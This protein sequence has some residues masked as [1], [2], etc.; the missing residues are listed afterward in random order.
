M[1]LCLLAPVPMS[2]SPHKFSWR[3]LYHHCPHLPNSHP[4]LRPWQSTALHC[5]TES[6]LVEVT[7][8][9]LIANC[10]IAS[11]SQSLTW[12]TALWHLNNTLASSSSNS[13]FHWLLKFDSL[14]SSLG[15]SDIS[16]LLI[17]MH[18]YIFPPWLCEYFL[19]KDILIYYIL[20]ICLSWNA[21]C[22]DLTFFFLAIN[23]F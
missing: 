10:R 5:L 8:C 13:P 19:L 6:I 1:A 21:K 20:H 22:P 3:V 17:Y 12:L 11:D 4:V 2:L 23:T 18:T 14:Q 7:N 15:H 16:F 9:C